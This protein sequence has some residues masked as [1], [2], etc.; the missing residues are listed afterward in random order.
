M[1]EKFPY[2]SAFFCERVLLEKDEVLSAIR[3]ADIFQIPE[4]P[5]EN[6]LIQFWLVLNVK[7]AI[8]SESA[9][10]R[11]MCTLIRS[12]GDRVVIVP[13]QTVKPMR[14]FDD[15]SIQ[16]SLGFIAQITLKPQNM[17]TAYVEVQIEDEV[18]AKVPFT[19]RPVSSV[20]LSK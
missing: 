8:E 3:I 10:Y 5:P 13:E 12:T 16:T 18:I 1:A 20:A 19:L 17:G 2:V 14:R 7:I 6:F 11:L 4:N 15:P 9:E